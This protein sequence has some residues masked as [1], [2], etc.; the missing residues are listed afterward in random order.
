MMECR[1]ALVY[2]TRHTDIDQQI[3]RNR[4]KIDHLDPGGY[5]NLQNLDKSLDERASDW[6]GAVRYLKG[7]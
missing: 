7:D 1:V 2:D 5:R 6:A 4:A 3:V